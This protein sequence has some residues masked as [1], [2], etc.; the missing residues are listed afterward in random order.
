MLLIVYHLILAT[1]IYRSSRNQETLVPTLVDI[2]V[3]S[4]NDWDLAVDASNACVEDVRN[5]GQ[6]VMKSSHITNSS[7]SNPIQSIHNPLPPPA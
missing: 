1:L 2:N 4:M 6:K 3:S 7:N 5:L